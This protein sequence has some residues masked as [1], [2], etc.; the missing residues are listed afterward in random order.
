MKLQSRNKFQL[1][2]D[3]EV[4][5]PDRELVKLQCALLLTSSP[6]FFKVSIPDR[7]LVKLQFKYQF[8][9]SVCSLNMFQSLIGS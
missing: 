3:A 9:S 8:H 1:A 5:I 7:E 4:S 2:Q 6:L